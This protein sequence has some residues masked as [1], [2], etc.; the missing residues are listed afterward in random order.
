MGLRKSARTNTKISECYDTIW[1]ELLH[2]TVADAWEKIVNRVK[3]EVVCQLYVLSLVH[4]TCLF[5]QN[6]LMSF[7][8]YKNQLAKNPSLDLTLIINSPQVAQIK[9]KNN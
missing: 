2:L 7:L 4:G 8:E 9:Q 6:W 3:E 5:Q 1:K